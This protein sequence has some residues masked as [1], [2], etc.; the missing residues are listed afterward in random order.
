MV[1]EIIRT[2]AYTIG[3][4]AVTN[5][6][7]PK[8]ARRDKNILADIHTGMETIAQIITSEVIAIIIE[9]KSIIDLYVS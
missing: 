6:T 3:P 4:T 8:L 5:M 1:V 9:A 7:R 2:T